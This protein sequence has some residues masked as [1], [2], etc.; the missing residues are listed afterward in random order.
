MN[1]QGTAATADQRTAKALTSLH[2]WGMCGGGGGSDRVGERCWV[3][4]SAAGASY[5]LVVQR[6]TVLAVGAGGGVLFRC[7]F[8]HFS[9]SGR[10]LYNID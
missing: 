10:W 2:S 8:S 6:P 5:L 7:H 9:L 1:A 3:P 4:F